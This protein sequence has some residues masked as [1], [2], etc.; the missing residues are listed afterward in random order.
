MGYRRHPSPPVTKMTA[1]NSR[2]MLLQ[3]DFPVSEVPGE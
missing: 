3:D 2:G 1:S